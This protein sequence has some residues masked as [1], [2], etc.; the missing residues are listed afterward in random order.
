MEMMVAMVE[1]DAVTAVVVMVEA[2]AG[3]C[4]FCICCV[5]WNK[6]YQINQQYHNHNMRIEHMDQEG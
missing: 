1:E 6:A 4:I 3:G 5:N 2:E